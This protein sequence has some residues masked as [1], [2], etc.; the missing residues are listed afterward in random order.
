MKKNIKLLTYAFIGCTIGCALS[1]L[2]FY[3]LSKDIV[4]KRFSREQ[5]RDPFGELNLAPLSLNKIYNIHT[6]GRK[7]FEKAQKD[8]QKY[9][10]EYEQLLLS[11]KDIAKLKVAYKKIIDAKASI[12][13]LHFNTT[14][15]VHSL[16]TLEQIKKLR[17]KDHRPPRMGRES[18][19]PRGPKKRPPRDHSSHGPR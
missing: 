19:P 14:N 8:L 9:K 18:R 2:Y 4:S 16:L 10:D 3:D 7:N 15:S 13:W 5:K 12:D 6:S 17:E 11:T 1:S